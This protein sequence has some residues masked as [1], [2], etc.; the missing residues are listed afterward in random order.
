MFKIKNIVREVPPEDTSLNIYF[1]DDG[2]QGS[3][4]NFCHNLFIPARTQR[5]NGFNT[6]TYNRV[7]NDIEFLVHSRTE[8]EIEKLSEQ[9]LTYASFADI[10]LDINNNDYGVPPLDGAETLYK[11]EEFIEWLD[12]PSTR[13]HYRRYTNWQADTSACVAKFL[14]IV[15]E[16]NWSVKRATGYCQGD[17]VDVIYCNE[18]YPNCAK[19][20]G[21]VWL[22]AAKEFAVITLDEDGQE[23][24][25]CYG[26]IVADCEA[27]N[28]ADYKRIVCEQAGIDI[29]ETR[30][31]MIESSRT[32]TKH[33]YRIA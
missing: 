28:D 25:S 17:V 29:A 8:R 27:Q 7:I 11:L 22:G 4:Q 20:Y 33:T 31:E 32:Y 9:T 2:L 24:D 23:N 1:D 6:E 19:K 5:H 30:L 21:E 16:K 18:F 3:G 14:T 26:F 13:P 12:E 10:V 15:T